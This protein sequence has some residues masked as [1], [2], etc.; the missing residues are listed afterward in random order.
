[1]NFQTYNPK[2]L[3]LES[4]R[5]FLLE[6]QQAGLQIRVDGDNFVIEIDHT[7]SIRIS[8]L[9]NGKFQIQGNINDFPSAGLD[10]VDNEGALRAT[11]ANCFKKLTGKNIE[12]W[13]Q[14][15]IRINVGKPATNITK[16]AKLIEGKKIE[17]FFDPYLENRSLQTLTDM[18]S[19]SSD[20]LISKNIRLISTKKVF[21]G[22]KKR[23]TR[24]YVEAWMLEHEATEGG[25]K[26]SIEY[27]H[28]RFMILNDGAV[29]IIGCSLGE[30]DKNEAA[31]VEADQGD[32][33]FFNNQWSKAENLA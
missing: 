7:R 29:L 11:V 22:K 24:S 25:I 5:I 16:L 23:L 32:V 3:S 27:E 15:T 12:T 4:V 30:I 17:A 13:R 10:D 18:S 9:K 2:N 20:S 8:N 6:L 26:I 14:T 19:L 31:H 28:R 33:E 1:M 21:E